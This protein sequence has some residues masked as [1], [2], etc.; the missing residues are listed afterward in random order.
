MDER[1]TMSDLSRRDL[2]K[3]GSAAAMV[4][5]GA[6]VLDL[7]RPAPAAAQTP[8][9]GGTFRLRSHVQPPHFDPHA[10]PGLLDHDPAVLRLQPAREGQGRLLGGPGTPRSS[11]TLRSPGP[12]PTT[13]PMS[14]SS[15]KGVRWHPKPPVNGRELTADD[16]KFTYERSLTIKGNPQPRARS[17]RWT[18]SRRSDKHT[19]RFTLKEPFAWFVECAGLHLPGSWPRKRRE[20]RRPQEA[21]VG[22]SGTGPWMLERYEPERPP[23]ASCATRP[24]S[25]RASRTS[26]RGGHDRHDPASG[27]RRSWPASTTSAR[28]TT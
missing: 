1:L 4:G 6:Q 5:A 20:V 7:A 15:S 26:T 22:R 27:L 28:S 2:L 19:V 14:S 8:K 11:P 12:S 23:D 9:R 13:P 21:G 10:D 17:R 3:L 18:R 16:V 25:C 24:T